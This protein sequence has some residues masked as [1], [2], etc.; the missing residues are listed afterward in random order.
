MEI[1]FKKAG[2]ED[3]KLIFKW[4]NDEIVRSNSFNTSQIDFESHVRWFRNKMNSPDCVLYVCYNGQTPIGQIR[5][6]IEKDVGIINYMVDEQFRG[7]GY[8]TEFLK[9]VAHE[10]EKENVRI[11]KLLGRAKYE[12]IAS[13]KAFEKAG[14]GSQEFEDYIEYS[15]DINM[16]K[17]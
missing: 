2:I 1:T 12:N 17:K 9:R 16:I 4:A 13:Q 15:I 3:C 14:Y 8:G 10:I 6:D 11:S 7:M 5:I